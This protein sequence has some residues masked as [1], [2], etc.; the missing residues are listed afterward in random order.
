MGEGS[1]REDSRKS[2]QRSGGRID[3]VRD[4]GLVDGCGTCG[5]ILLEIMQTR[6]RNGP[7]VYK[8]APLWQAVVWSVAT[9]P[10]I[11]IARWAAKVVFDGTGARETRVRKG[12]KPAEG[13]IEGVR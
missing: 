12:P 13:C 10:D 1:G 2:F 6:Q 11:A 5:G 3:V 7:K 9:S 4:R 8:A